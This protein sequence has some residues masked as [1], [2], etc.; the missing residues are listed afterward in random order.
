MFLCMLSGPYE[1]KQHILLLLTKLKQLLPT[2]AEQYPG[3]CGPEIQDV[4]SDK[5][6]K[7]ASVDTL[8]VFDLLVIQPFILMTERQLY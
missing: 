2:F 3:D 1:W 7:Q 5:A 6:Q 4:E 8:D